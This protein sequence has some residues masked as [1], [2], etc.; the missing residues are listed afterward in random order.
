MKK[1]ILPLLLVMVLLLAALSVTAIAAETPIEPNNAS[2]YANAEMKGK[3][4]PEYPVTQ[5]CPVCNAE[6]KWYPLDKG[7]TGT[8]VIDYNHYY[9]LA[10][11]T[12]TGSGFYRIPSGKT[13]CMYMN[14][15]NISSEA[16]HAP[17]KRHSDEFHHLLPNR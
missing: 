14:G 17:K 11:I 9:L 4:G 2:A 13:V 6:K 1:R 15:Y 10:N 12:H 7:M 8:G 16:Y 5:Y 3:F